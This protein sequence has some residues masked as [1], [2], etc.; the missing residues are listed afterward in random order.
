MPQPK[1]LSPW[2]PQ[3]CHWLSPLVCCPLSSKASL[4]WYSVSPASAPAALNETGRYLTWVLLMWSPQ[5]PWTKQRSEAELVPMKQ[6]NHCCHFQGPLSREADFQPSWESCHRS[7][8]TEIQVKR[9][10]FCQKPVGSWFLPRGCCAGFC[11]NFAR[12]LL[13]FR[14]IW[15][16]RRAKALL[17]NPDAM[18]PGIKTQVKPR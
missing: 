11:L 14:K 4:W 5:M 3:P 12:F 10:G 1:A 17:H 13:S 9:F 8:R 7:R 2:L 18:N 6:S 15:G 16:K